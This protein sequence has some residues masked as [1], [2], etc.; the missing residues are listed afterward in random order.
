VAI[1]FQL[2][3]DGADPERLCR[4][5]VAA[6]RYELE[7]PPDGFTTWE[8]YWRDVGVPEE[9]LGIG[10]GRISDPGGAG[11]R[12]WFQVVPEPNTV[13]N[14]IHLDIFAS[15]GRAVPIATRK[16][17]AD[18][19]ARRLITLGATMIRVLEKEGLDHYGVAMKDPEGNEPDINSRPFLPFTNPRSRR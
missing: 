11:P 18:A 17:R 5:G 9:D 3:I 1:N 8:E 6:H 13:K 12:I 14:R 10:A 7:P 15:G 16:Q 4:F 2:V 19:A